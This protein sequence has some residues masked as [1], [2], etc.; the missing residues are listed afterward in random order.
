MST[1]PYP[2]ALKSIIKTGPVCIVFIG[3]G[4]LFPT[5]LYDILYHSA[6]RIPKFHFKF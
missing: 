2:A 4:V 6:E 5:V 1:S 3:F